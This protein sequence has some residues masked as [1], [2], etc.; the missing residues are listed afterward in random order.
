VAEQ[1]KLVREEEAEALELLHKPSLTIEEI[2]ATF[3]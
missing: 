3:G 2:K 1:A